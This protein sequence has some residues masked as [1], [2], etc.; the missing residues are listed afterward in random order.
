MHAQ[1]RDHAALAAQF[2]SEL[3]LVQHRYGEVKARQEAAE[4]LHADSQSASI[5]TA[6]QLSAARR[7][8]QARAETE[9]RLQQTVSNLEEERDLL[10]RQLEEV[11]RRS[12]TDR[13]DLQ[14]AIA[15][16]QEA[17]ER[18]EELKVLVTN[19]ETTVHSHSQK[20]HRL[21]AEVERGG[22][23]LQ[24][25]EAEKARLQTALAEKD[26]R[27]REQQESL[28]K[29]DRERDRLQE[30]VDAM[31]EEADQER[32]VRRN[33]EQQFSSLKLVLEQTE[34]KVQTISVELT[35]AQRHAQAADA[36]LNASQLEVTELK[37]RFS[38]KSIEIG[39]AA[40]D[41]MLMTRENQALTSELVEVSAERD[42]LQQRLQQVLHASAST[43]HARRSVEVERSDL[44]NTY[45]TVL[46]EKR[47]LEEDLSQLRYIS[48]NI[49]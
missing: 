7:D 12:K 3:V 25:W 6:Q 15:E 36:R 48:R 19:L 37:R 41:L 20:Q 21:A 22:E 30:Q 28:Q 8:L 39:G 14:R 1:C 38:Q 5:G 17:V 18:T 23:E 43:E 27:V 46:Q 26:R 29:I 11:S 35:S 47:K 9:M 4:A 49:F 42:R 31:E 10:R 45:R 24:H 40:E 32:A 34:R 2:Q 13:A 16:R 33:H 44:L